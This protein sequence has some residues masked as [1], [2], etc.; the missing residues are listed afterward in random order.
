MFSW[1]VLLF[2]SL[3]FARASG[4]ATISL[5][6]NASQKSSATQATVQVPPK[7][8]WTS[9]SAQKWQPALLSR[10]LIREAVTEERGE[11]VHDTYSHELRGT[12]CGDT[13]S[14]PPTRIFQ[15]FY[16]NGGNCW[17]VYEIRRYQTYTATIVPAQYEETYVPRL[18][19]PLAKSIDPQKIS[20]NVNSDHLVYE[21]KDAAGQ[22]VRDFYHPAV[23]EVR[24]NAIVFE[25]P[26]VDPNNPTKGKIDSY[27]KRIEYQ[28]T[29]LP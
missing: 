20:V 16:W 28:M 22:T 6:V 15:G 2:V 7:E 23:K 19:V 3:F 21:Y 10:R 12:Y 25:I 8:I 24:S 18:E 9:A 27:P 29:P 1:L 26:D 4:A 11:W 14:S 5:K 17:A 13:S